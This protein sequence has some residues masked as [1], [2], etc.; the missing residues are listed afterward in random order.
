LSGWSLRLQAIP[1]NTATSPVHGLAWATSEE[2]SRRL[3]NR[4]IALYST[5]RSEF[6]DYAVGPWVSVAGR[7]T[8]LARGNPAL[9]KEEVRIQKKE[10]FPF[11]NS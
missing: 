7:E 5:L 2:E 1:A 4:R 8:A 9:R 3:Q 10:M 6:C 11:L